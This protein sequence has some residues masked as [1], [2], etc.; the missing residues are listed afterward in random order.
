[1]LLFVA[2]SNCYVAGVGQMMVGFGSAFAFSLALKSIV[3]WF[4]AKSVALMTSCTISIGSLGPVIG[5]P[6]LSMLVKSFDWTSV[7][8]VFS[9]VGLLI[10]FLAWMKV[11]GKKL[12]PVGKSGGISL[13]DSLKMIVMSSQ[14]W[15][16]SIFTMMIYSPLSA[17]GDLWGIS[18]IKKVYGVDAT[19]AAF[20]NNML[21]VGFIIG[22][23][24]FAALAKAW[25][26]YKKPMLSAIISATVL[27]GIITFANVPV[28]VAFILFLLLGFCC[29]AVLAFPLA[30]EIFPAAIGAT[31]TGFVN[32]ACMMSGVILM[33]LIGWIL[34]LSWN[35][36]MENG[37]K[38][39]SMTDYRCALSSVLVFLVIGIGFAL[40]I[41][42]KSHKK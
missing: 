21:Y 28:N 15:V 5:G 18:F 30:L 10:A 32:M 36:A 9:L 12:P 16:L 19:T 8:E 1:V 22:T 25:G 2:T 34:D 4:P 24:S 33:W 38:V 35:G 41:R 13:F 39:Y 42:D 37:L 27:F 26:S 11:R 23:P 29:G 6:A 17:L 14:L 40:F 20:M 7:L 3:T 31:V